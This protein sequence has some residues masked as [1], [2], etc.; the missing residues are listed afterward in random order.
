MYTLIFTGFIILGDS[1]TAFY[2]RRFDWKEAIALKRGHTKTRVVAR[3]QGRQKS[4]KGREK[5]P[6]ARAQ[7]PDKYPRELKP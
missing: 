5:S 4:P 1:S 3:N 6:V 7:I 2:F